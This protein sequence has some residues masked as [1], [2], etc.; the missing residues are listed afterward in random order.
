MK[1]STPYWDKLAAYL[2]GDLDEAERAE[3]DLWIK[4]SPQNER[5]FAEAK[6]I[7]E[8][9]GVRLE[10]H[11]A[12]T[13]DEWSRL[14]SKIADDDSRSQEVQLTGRYGVWLKLAASIL[15]L[16]VALFILW[17]VEK[18]IDISAGDQVATFYLPDS[19]KVWLNVGS[20]LSYPE[21]F[22]VENRRIA[23]SGEGYFAVK[24]DSLKPF[25]VK[26]SLA[27]A[28]VLGTSFNI[29]EDSAGVVLTVA[30]GEVSFSSMKS[31]NKQK[32]VV[33]AKEKAVVTTNEGPVKSQNLDPGFSAWRERNNAIYEQE[34]D[35]PKA[36][37]T[38]TYRWEKNKINMSVIDGKLTNQAGLAIYTDIVLDAI[39]TK[40]NGK[41]ST[42]TFTITDK[43]QP[44]QTV[45]YEKRLMDFLTDTKKV[46]VELKSVRVISSADL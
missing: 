6:Q 37:L 9:S 5:E 33:T 27:Y 46:E 11:D 21:D 24:A 42:T 39:Y 16:A 30:E 2:S 17:P 34:K 1:E 29:K 35:N 25:I 43:I 8:N 41:T 23:L 13:E 45:S 19:S 40:P 28:R 14:K 36:Y 3:V 20:K 18:M 10:M 44:G 7:W 4:S 22:G 26:A 32:V 15:I 12:N 38:S 31:K